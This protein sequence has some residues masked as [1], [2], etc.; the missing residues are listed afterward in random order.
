[1]SSV[2]RLT[3]LT[4]VNITLDSP[5]DIRYAEEIASLA[6]DIEIRDKI[7]AHSFPHPYG[8]ENAVEFIERNRDTGSVP[9]AVDFLILYKNRAAGIVGLSDI[10]F[11]DRKAHIGY[12]V[13]RQFRGKGIATEAVGLACNYAFG[14]LK[15]RRLQTKVLEGNLA[16]MRVLINNGFEVEGIEQDAFFSNDKY[17]SFILFSRIERIPAPMR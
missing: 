13:G 5:I 6:N 1:M 8:V 15:L 7:G 9:F 11:L 10:N 17:T 12:W 14:E 3:K 4:G 16:S 2:S